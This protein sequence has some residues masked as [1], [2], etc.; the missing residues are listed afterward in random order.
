MEPTTHSK[1]IND[2][3]LCILINLV[4]LPTKICKNPLIS[5]DT[6]AAIM[7]KANL[8]NTFKTAGRIIKQYTTKTCLNPKTTDTNKPSLA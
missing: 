4:P 7:Q 5:T 3:I 2:H 1:I 6:F 8:I